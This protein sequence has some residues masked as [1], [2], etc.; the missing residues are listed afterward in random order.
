[1]LTQHD[2]PIRERGSVL[3]RNQ[4]DALPPLK[5]VIMPPLMLMSHELPPDSSMH[6]EPDGVRTGNVVAPLAA[7]RCLG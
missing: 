3:F 4:W 6:A 2:L 7:A 1:M 5:E